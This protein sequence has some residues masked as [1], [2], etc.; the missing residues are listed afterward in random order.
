VQVIIA[1]ER[2]ETIVILHGDHAGAGR[3][4]GNVGFRTA[5]KAIDRRVEF[6]FPNT[7]FP[8]EKIEKGYARMPPAP[9]VDPAAIDTSRVL[10]DREGIARFN[11]QRFEMIQLTAIV[12]INVE[13]KLVIGYKD[14]EA[15]EF[16]VRGHMPDYPLMPGVLM[17]EAAAQLCSFFCGHIQLNKGGFIGFGGMEDVRFRGQIRPGDRLVLVAKARRLHH[18]QT[19]FDCQGFVGTNMVFHGKIIGVSIPSQEEA[20]AAT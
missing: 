1:V 5:G 17:C 18:R 2:L 3:W 4:A 12:H 14:V 9:L 10:V 15:D 16:W 19:M 8:W 20:P 6:A 13:E 11:P 7:L